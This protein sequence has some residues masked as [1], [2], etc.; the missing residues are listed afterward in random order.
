MSH[1][2]LFSFIVVVIVAVLLIATL[3]AELATVPAPSNVAVS[4]VST[5]ETVAGMVGL[6][7]LPHQHKSFYD[8]GLWWFFYAAYPDAAL[9]GSLCYI[10]S[11]N[12]GATWSTPTTLGYSVGY[13]AEWTLAY[14][15]VNGKVW[16]GL[17]NYA[18]ATSGEN[19]WGFIVRRGSPQSNGTITWDAAWQTAIAATT[20]VSD[21]NMV[22]DTNQHLWIGYN[23]SI[24]KNANTDGTWATAPGFPVR[25]R[26]NQILAPLS[27]G[28]VYAVN[29]EWGYNIRSIGYISTTGSSTFTAE[30]NITALPVED[31]ASN[32]NT[33]VGRIFA[34][35]LGDG[36]AHVVY[37]STTG[38]IRYAQRN[39]N[40]VWA[41][42]V[43]L[44][45]GAEPAVSSPMLTFNQKNGDI[46][47]TWTAYDTLYCAV[48]HNNSWSAAFPIYNASFEDSYEHAISAQL[49]D[50]S[51]TFL[52]NTLD[53]SYNL[54]TLK[55]AT[56]TQRTAT[57]L[58]ATAPPTASANQ[59]FTINGTPSTDTTGIVDANITLQRSVDN[60]TWTTLTTS[61]TNGTAWYAFSRNESAAGTYYYRTGYA[62]NS[63]YA[64]A[65]SNVV[66]V[67]VKI[68]A[69]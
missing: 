3:F 39:A 33:Y 40:G 35:G 11:S 65:T 68:L 46:M 1:A 27:N 44:A 64:N 67:T 69:A 8:A 15:T 38:Q 23:G 43:V 10:T 51:G 63:T 55:V 7:R 6:S 29:Y 45:T 61:T 59:N 66:K 60:A 32:A 28:G 52:V 14:N 30:G 18:N 19:N 22:I 21:P 56:A 42:E 16:V 24:T 49:T 5:I 9:P 36:I 13:D 20:A 26:G 2:R 50:T 58:T 48:N 12:G 4:K 41:P 34:D 62:G 37:Q 53:S 47:V 57:N 17:S 31:T 25:L 54:L